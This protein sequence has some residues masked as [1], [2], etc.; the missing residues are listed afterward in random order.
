MKN[1][2]RVS[3]KGGHL[4]SFTA[5]QNKGL[6]DYSTSGYKR[7]HWQYF[8]NPFCSPCGISAWVYKIDGKVIG[9]IG[10][11]PVQ[12]NA[13]ARKI[14]A[15]WAVDFMTLSQYR[16]KGIGRALVDETNKH[17]D[18]LMAI[19]ITEMSFRLFMKMGWRLL[20]NIPYYMMVWECKGLLKRKFG[21]VF[22]LNLV[23]TP[24][25]L[26]LKGFN[27]F[28][29]LTSKTKV[30][31]V[32]RIDSFDKEPEEFF[33]EITR[34]YKILVPRSKSYLSW[35]YDR[36][37]YMDYVKLKAID[38]NKSCGYSVIRCIKCDSAPPEGLIVDI[39]AQPDDIT[40]IKSLVLASFEYFMKEGCPLVRC[41]ASHKGI[42][43]TLLS[44]GM[45][46]RKSKMRF[47]VSKD[48]DGLDKHYDL[49]NWHI[50]SGDCDIDRI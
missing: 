31:E 26:L 10:T 32:R 19:G 25:N 12:L 1:I 43:K 36:Q 6:I 4:E 39:I 38:G 16:R 42:Q 18:I 15:A 3:N 50:T 44:C 17:F 28:K 8:E 46:R 20:G 21:D 48:I 22:I 37:P 24:I 13:G 27:Y 33:E 11:I 47:L 35:K 2:I 41:Y 7:W 49:A 23:S 29:R 40:S 14:N 45:I 9:H 30:T 34:N 5:L